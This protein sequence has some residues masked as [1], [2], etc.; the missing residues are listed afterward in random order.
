METTEILVLS[1]RVL[2]ALMFIWS[3]Y[4]KIKAPQPLA[5]LLQSK[6]YKTP[7]GLVRLV[8]ACEITGA[9]LLIVDVMLWQ[10]S[11]ALAVFV[12]AANFV[13]NNFW[14]LEGMD[15]VHA[16]H[17]FLNG[18]GMAAGLFFIAAVSYPVS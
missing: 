14:A 10:V 13:A 8:G 7:P 18:I 1:A 16:Q 17:K 6:G 2:M 15:A 4:G 9:G 12:V 3:G 5:G 11:L